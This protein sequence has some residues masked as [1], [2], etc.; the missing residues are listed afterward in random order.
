MEECIC[1]RRIGHKMKED[2]TFSIDEL[3][4]RIMSSIRVTHRGLEAREISK[5]RFKELP[6]PVLPGLIKERDIKAPCTFLSDDRHSNT[7]PVD[8]SERW[9]LSVAQAA[10][11]LNATT[12]SA[13]MPLPRR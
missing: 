3:R 8:L 7:T 10:L 13:L 5:L 9:G 4:N 11:T 2:L 12:R 6:P 1:D